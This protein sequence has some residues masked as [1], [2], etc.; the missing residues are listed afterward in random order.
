MFKG[1]PHDL[2]HIQNNKY[3][4]RLWKNISS[5]ND[6]IFLC[7]KWYIGNGQKIRFWDDIWCGTEKFKDRFPHTFAIAKNKHASVWEA[8]GST[9]HASWNVLTVRN[10][11][12]WELEDYES[13]LFTLAGINLTNRDDKLT[14]NLNKNG[15]FSVNLLY[16]FLDSQKQNIQ[17]TFPSKIIWKY[18]APP[19]I[20]FFA[21]EAAK[22]KI[23]TPDNLMKRCHTIV[24]RCFFM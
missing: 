17:R 14:W 16:R 24:N 20:P 3:G 5:L 23:L 1:N 4:I 12:D 11:N 18:G 19:R 22:G 6:A 13:M 7:S 8:A 21:W 9:C 2:S 10:L 15:I